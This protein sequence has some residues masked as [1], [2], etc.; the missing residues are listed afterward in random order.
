MRVANVM[1]SRGLGGI[2]QAVVDYSEALQLTGHE[3]WAVIH[4][5]A[6]VKNKLLHINT[7]FIT[8]PNLGAWDIFAILKLRKLL[9]T[10][11]ID[12]CIGHGNRALSLLKYA[13]DWKKLVAVT[14][15]YKIKCKG[16]KTVFCPTKD[17]IRYAEKQGVSKENIFHIPNMVR[18][19]AQR[20]PY[21]PRKM[22]VVGS[23]GRFVAKK[24]FDMFIQSLD[25]LKAK[26]VPFSAIL[27][28]DGEE[29]EALKA[30]AA[31]RGLDNELSFPG[32]VDNKQD[33]FE[34]IDLFCLPSHHEPFGI[35]LLE[36]MAY[37]LPVISTNSEGPSEILTDHI[38]G[39]LVEK[40]SAA[41]MA[42]AIENLLADE[43][44]AEV[45]A[46]NAYEKVKNNYDLPVISK[47]LA[48]ALESL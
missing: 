4:P 17:L 2:E 29:T 31:N 34:K 18:L 43:Q 36:A 47:K 28:G 13:V 5:D 10:L 1:L 46:R 35:V 3:V 25:M 16:V 7:Q 39:I 24:G 23:M 44:K 12:V 37:G 9:K 22:P 14:H 26:L 48:L 21:R 45:L 20:K 19:P 38:N 32:W 40:G 30:L 42:E 41:A 27:A 15:N 33:F 8:L 6:A 11:Q